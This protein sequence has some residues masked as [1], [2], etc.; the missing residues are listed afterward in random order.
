MTAFLLVINF[1]IEGILILAF[2]NLSARTKKTE[3]LELKQQ[4]VA[5][6]I[7]DLFTSY[8]MEIKEENERMTDLLRS[9]EREPHASN[10]SSPPV[11]SSSEH[12]STIKSPVEEQKDYVPPAPDSTDESYQPTLQSQ[13]LL[14]KDQGL[15]NDQIAKRLNRGK[16]EI[17]LVI[18]FKQKNSGYDLNERF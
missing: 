2:I 7:E 1:I 5:S 12:W 6:E 14:L 16:T 4:K 17:E 11:D 13:V 15:S 8:L 3:E 9:K 18:K 10:N